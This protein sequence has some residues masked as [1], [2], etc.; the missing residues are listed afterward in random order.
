M[1]APL[2]LLFGLATAKEP[3][4]PA[5]ALRAVA[6]PLPA[7]PKGWPPLGAE[8]GTAPLPPFL[9]RPPPEVVPCVLT[10]PAG[11]AVRSRHVDL[12]RFSVLTSSTRCERVEVDGDPPGAAIRV[13]FTI[14][15][16]PA[17]QLA[18]GI[19]LLAV[20]RGSGDASTGW[21]EAHDN[22][23]STVAL[24]ERRYSAMLLLTEGSKFRLELTYRIEAINFWETD[25]G[26][27][28]DTVVK[29]YASKLS[30][31]WMNNIPSSVLRTI[32]VHE[33]Q[34]YPSGLSLELS[35]T[36]SLH[37]S[38]A[39]P[40]CEDVG[41]ISRIG[42]TIFPKDSTT[43]TFASVAHWVPS[44]CRMR[45]FDLSS[46]ED[47]GLIPGSVK[48]RL[49]GD[50]NCQKTATWLNGPGKLQV[51]RKDPKDKSVHGPF[52]IGPNRFS[53]SYR[54][55][56]GASCGDRITPAIDPE[57]CARGKKSAPP[58]WTMRCERTFAPDGIK[59]VEE[60]GY[61]TILINAGWWMVVYRP[62]DEWHQFARGL[63][64]VLLDCAERLPVLRKRM[65]IFWME[66]MATN[67]TAGIGA[68]SAW[69]VLWN[70][71]IRK[72]E[73]V[74]QQH[75]GHLVDGIVPMNSFTAPW[76]EP[77]ND[78]PHRNHV[79]PEIINMALNYA[80]WGAKR[81]GETVH[82]S[83]SSR[84]RRSRARGASERP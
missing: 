1:R 79:Y 57:F 81:R 15:E 82:R 39:L 2:L 19:R 5:E 59:G 35:T 77:S 84:H 18:S 34:I 21:I 51:F 72:Y 38:G 83:S 9:T 40:L 53:F 8:N 41:G 46:A 6:A 70:D 24:N 55:F 33:Q 47:M 7:G 26:K 66:T 36:Q 25:E 17:A 31:E 63:R 13:E 44:N 10:L 52:W 64:D 22:A 3:P 62:P 16:Y 27:K 74:I 76:K 45:R 67:Q 49:M 50:S 48:I 4:A 30:T 71:R 75:I 60:G 56:R 54:F 11:Q 12:R 28:F 73:A 32:G 61:N 58:N 20:E 14:V 43:R 69:R 42:R 23:H 37:S 78:D 65:S 29:S 80:L 68:T